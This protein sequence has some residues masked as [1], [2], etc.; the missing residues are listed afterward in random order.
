M[1]AR[2]GFRR[3]I[4]TDEQRAEEERVRKQIEDEA[5]EKEL[6]ALF[7]S[8]EEI[9]EALRKEKERRQTKT[10]KEITKSL[11]SSSSTKRTPTPAPPPGTYRS[12]SP[13]SY[14]RFQ[15]ANTPKS[16][17]ISPAKGAISLPSQFA[18]S[19]PLKHENLET[20]LS[21]GRSSTP[22][23][24]FR[25]P[26]NKGP[27]LKPGTVPSRSQNPGEL[28]ADRLV[29]GYKQIRRERKL[30]KREDLIEEV[31]RREAEEKERE[32]NIANPI[33]TD[34][35]TSS[36]ASLVSLQDITAAPEG[37]AVGQ[38]NVSQQDNPQGTGNNANDNSAG[39]SAGGGAG[40]STGDGGGGEPPTPSLE[41]G[42]EGELEEIVVEG[43]GGGGAAAPQ[44]GAGA[45]P[46]LG[47]GGAGQKGI[48]M[49]GENPRGPGHKPG[50]PAN[51]LGA[52]GGPGQQ[53]PQSNQHNEGQGPY[54]PPAYGDGSAFAEKAREGD[55]DRQDPITPATGSKQTP[56]TANSLV[57]AD[58][59]YASAKKQSTEKVFGTAQ[60]RANAGMG[61]PSDWSFNGPYDFPSRP[62]GRPDTTLTAVGG[63]RSKTGEHSASVWKN[64]LTARGEPAKKDNYYKWSSKGGGNWK[65][66]SARDSMRVFTK[67]EAKRNGSRWMSQPNPGDELTHIMGATLK[68]KMQDINMAKKGGERLN[69]RRKGGDPGNNFQ[70]QV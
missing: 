1:A 45:G 62:S 30:R 37:P 29:A 61:A 31:R 32:A 17:Y 40:S 48:A 63:W 44:A 2:L 35:A 14:S 41:E 54:V 15:T 42:G 7:Q 26:F 67:M 23:S 60:E 19:S 70:T 55:S 33:R 34:H 16:P 65:N 9:R 18:G 50:E 64:T 10:P 28:N 36:D 68:R 4:I 53:P 56:A 22:L 13:S 39:S 11:A 5:K 3:N 69:K 46:L 20:R 49:H 12:P 52:A 21:S 25:S 58:P 51:P 6:S 43:G 24:D 59:I 57:G 47:A 8:Q 27:V 66:L 38:M